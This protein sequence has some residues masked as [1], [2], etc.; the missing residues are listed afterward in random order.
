[1]SNAFLFEGGGVFYSKVHRTFWKIIK[2]AKLKNGEVSV[3]DEDEALG[4]IMERFKAWYQKLETPPF[5]KMVL[6]FMIL[7]PRKSF[8]ERSTNDFWKKMVNFGKKI[9]KLKRV[10][11]L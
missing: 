2:S 8:I 3:A 5:L 6:S 4:M 10:T 1:M 9:K 11:T 7:H